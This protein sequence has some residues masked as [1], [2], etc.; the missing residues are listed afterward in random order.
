M[1]GTERCKCQNYEVRIDDAVG[2]ISL[3]LKAKILLSETNYFPCKF[4]YIANKY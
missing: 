4:V 1:G 3:T 2:T